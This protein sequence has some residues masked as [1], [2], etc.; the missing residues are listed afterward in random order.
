MLTNIQDRSIALLASQFRKGTSFDEFNNIEKLVYALLESGKEIFS[1][2]EDL[3]KKRY[4]DFSEG[5]Q[6][7]RLGEIVGIERLDGESDEDLRERIR[8]Q[9]FINS[10]T[11]TPEE[12]LFMIKT[13]TNADQV[14]IIEYFPGAFQLITDGLT[15]PDPFTDLNEALQSAS[16][17]SIQLIPVV[18]TFAVDKPFSFS[19]DF[20]IDPLVITDPNDIDAFT[21]LELDD[22][23]LL[24][25]VGASRAEGEG[26]GFAEFGN[27]IDTTGAGQLPEVIQIN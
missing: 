11:G 12:L 6:L 22:G 26:G 7:D 2:L 21:N 4:I 13:L 24:H 20:S 10:A 18:A 23:E 15:F 14:R 5:I 19:G 17:A 27:P 8:F 1:V 3:Q 25:V 9:P 16:P